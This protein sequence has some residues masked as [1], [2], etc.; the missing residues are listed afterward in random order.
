[1]NISGYTNNIS[2]PLK[3]KGNCTTRQGDVWLELKYLSSP[4]VY[5]LNQK[6]N[7]TH[8]KM[9]YYNSN[10]RRQTQKILLCLDSET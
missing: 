5:E 1:M 2:F 10:L 9:F 6:D 4:M 8:F 3:Y 7:F